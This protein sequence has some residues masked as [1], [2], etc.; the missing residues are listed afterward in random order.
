[1]N[2]NEK[3]AMTK[4]IQFKD[5]H[6][7]YD[8]FVLDSVNYVKTF[9]Q[10]N[11]MIDLGIQTKKR[12]KTKHEKEVIE[13]LVDGTMTAQFHIVDIHK[14]LEWVKNEKISF[15]VFYFEDLKNK[16]YKYLS[17]DG[18][19]R[20]QL[21]WKYPN[22]S[23]FWKSKFRV[24][25]YKNLTTKEISEHAKRLNKGVAWNLIELR[26][27]KSVVSDFIRKNSDEY[28]ELLNKF[29]GSDVKELKRFK[30]LDILESFL[31]LHKQ[32]INKEKFD[33]KNKLKE[34]L[35]ESDVDG[36]LLKN[37][38]LSIIIFN[39]MFLKHLENYNRLNQM[40][41]VM[42]YLLSID[43]LEKNK[44]LPSE[45]EIIHLVNKFNSMCEKIINDK[46][47]SGPKTL[48]DLTVRKSWDKLNDRFDYA[49]N[50]I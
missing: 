10:E 38:T 32:F 26:N 5:F 43:F 4:K 34:I 18:N 11:T 35:R 20:T 33:T 16:G 28:S 15:D 23:D 14:C 21:L 29:A 39:K 40:F 22:V 7:S 3:L 8:E 41:Y 44:N 37:N 30:D 17:I 19:H 47:L 24:I 9:T 13:S 48:F 31:L 2:I 25:L 49:K 45:N 27:N 12:W 1:M 36:S 46:N 42:L 50:N 6:N